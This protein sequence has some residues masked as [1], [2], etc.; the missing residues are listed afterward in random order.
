MQKQSRG[1][2][3]LVHDVVD[4]HTV[5]AG[6]LMTI[7]RVLRELGFNP[8]N[9]LGKWGVNESGFEDP[10]NKLPYAAIDGLLADCAKTTRCPHF[11][12]L[13]GER[14]TSSHLGI[15]GF[16]LRSA[17]D[18]RTAL[19]DL[20]T[21]LDLHDRVGVVTLDTRGPD[22]F[23]GYAVSRG[24]LAALDQICDLSIAVA[25]NVMRDLCGSGFAPSSV[26]LSRRPPADT[27]P[28]EQFFNATLRFDATRDA[29]V[30]PTRWLEH[31]LAT[32]D[33]MMYRYFVNEAARLH[34][35]QSSGTVENLRRLLRISLV[36]RKFA[37]SIVAGQLGLHERTLNRRLRNE[38]TT[39]RR[40]LEKIRY[41]LARE[42]LADD[43]T[44]I[45]KIAG[46]LGYAD[47]STFDR[48]FKRWSGSSPTHWRE[49][50]AAG[51]SQV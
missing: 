22:T 40:E 19:T 39:Y 11:G 10:D 3:S 35:D 36:E 26:L 15:A 14:A 16:M 31:R 13:I 41:E 37:I 49:Y 50:S 18:V 9:L 29:L 20:Q 33:P 2:P 23:F 45:S 8:E 46:V 6:P 25:T 44:T 12:L 30:F 21:N 1:E 17:P 47:V 48:A 4:D 7:P 38:G 28:Y 42:M 51:S 34:R 43:R 27:A 24:G 32:S 5:R